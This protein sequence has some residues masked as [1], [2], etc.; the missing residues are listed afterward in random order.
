MPDPIS[1]SLALPF[2]L[3]A[4][5]FGYFVGSIPFGLIFARLAGLGDV[6]KIG[7]GSI[8]ATNV[9]RTGNK[10]VA[11]S[12]L[13]ADLLKGTF[14]Y[15]ITEHYYGIDM[16]VFAGLGAFLGHCFPVWLKFKGGKGVAVFIGITI[17]ILLKVTLTFAAIWITVASLSRLS[18]LASIIAAIITPPAFF[19]LGYAQA[20]ELFLLL[21]FILVIKHRD[22]IKRLLAGKENM[23]GGG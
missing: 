23:I 12:T 14:A 5:A 4:L 8:G 10:F 7:S 9:L 17:P 3:K 16:A 2:F 15:A 19:I 11:A 18:S 20:G 22:N 21:T 6:R 1:W 13:L